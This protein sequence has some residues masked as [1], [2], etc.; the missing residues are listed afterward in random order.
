MT[1]PENEVAEPRATT[2]SG[3]PK[4]TRDDIEAKL[5]EIAGPVEGNVDSAK[6]AGIAAAVAVG[7]VL[8]IAAFIIG[9]RRGRRRTP[10]IEIRRI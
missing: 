5:R 3:K 2:P 10:V 4:V 1:P 7:T 8:V 9:R 6:T